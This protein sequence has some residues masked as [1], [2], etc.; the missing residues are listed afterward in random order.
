MSKLAPIMSMVS[1]IE[2]WFRLSLFSPLVNIVID[3]CVLSPEF[4]Y[5]SFNR[6]KIPVEQSLSILV[7]FLRMDIDVSRSGVELDVDVFQ[8]L[9]TFARGDVL[10]ERSQS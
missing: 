3:L 5:F 8:E 1:E 6:I 4:R 9:F 10:P 2:C 7:N